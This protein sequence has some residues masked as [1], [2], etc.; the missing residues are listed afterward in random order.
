MGNEAPVKVQ[1]YS[2]PAKI[3][4]EMAPPRKK[5]TPVWRT[6]LWFIIDGFIV[7]GVLRLLS[8]FT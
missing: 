1:T 6:L 8:L 7:L 3:S 2:G 5:T 4:I